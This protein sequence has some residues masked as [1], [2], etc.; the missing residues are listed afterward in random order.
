MSATSLTSHGGRLGG[1]VVRDLSS[2]LVVRRHL[3]SLAR[4]GVLTG[5]EGQRQ[6]L[7]CGAFQYSGPG[8]EGVIQRK[9]QPKG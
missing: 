4:A 8:Y 7:C 2:Q 9:P 5:H 6:R 1:S 3:V